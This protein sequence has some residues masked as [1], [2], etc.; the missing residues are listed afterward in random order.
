MK[1]TAIEA[2]TATQQSSNKSLFLFAS[3]KKKQRGVSMVDIGIWAAVAVGV[4]IIFVKAIGPVLAQNRARDEIAEMAKV[5]TNI[6][7]KWSNA[8]SFNGVTLAQLINNDVFPRSWVNGAA[9]NNRWGGPVTIALSTMVTANDSMI[10]TSAS[11]PS[12][13]CKNITPGLVESVRVITVDGTVVKANG[14]QINMGTVGTACGNGAIVSIE[15]QI[16]KS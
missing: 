10:I 4:V 2:A 9:V 8:S 11:V 16:G 14:G 6:Q 12:E 15:Y 3:R 5:V 1:Q 13:E 7:S